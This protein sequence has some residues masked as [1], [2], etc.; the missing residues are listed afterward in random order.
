MKKNNFF[1]HPSSFILSPLMPIHRRYAGRLF[2]LLQPFGQ[3]AH[4][5]D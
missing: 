1:I 3:L 4:L 5:A 2:P